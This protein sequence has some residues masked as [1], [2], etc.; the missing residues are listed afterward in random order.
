MAHDWFDD[1][2]KALAGR[3]SRRSFFKGLGAAVAGAAV[4]GFAPAAAQTSSCH[5]YCWSQGYRGRAFGECMNQCQ[6]PGT[7]YVCDADA[8]CFHTGCS[9][10]I[11]ASE[12]VI[13]TCEFKCEYGCYQQAQC[14][15]IGGNRCGFVMT[16]ELQ[17]CLHACES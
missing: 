12:D 5:D 2:E 14:A 7:A 15:C 10:Q 13:T 9:G 4:G 11:C 1:V 3:A 16:S 8:D 17:A 6:S